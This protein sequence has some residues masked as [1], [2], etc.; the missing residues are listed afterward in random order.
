MVSGWYKRFIV[1]GWYRNLVRDGCGWYRR[2]IV[3]FKVY[4]HFC[5]RRFVVDTNVLWHVLWLMQMFLDTCFLHTTNR[6]SWMLVRQWGEQIFGQA[7]SSCLLL[8]SYPS[9]VT[10]GL[11]VAIQS[12]PHHHQTSHP[13]IPV[14]QPL[15]RNSR[16]TESPTGLYNSRSQCATQN[17]LL[18][19]APTF[20]HFSVRGAFKF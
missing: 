10:T 17:R 13:P 7:I 8:G 14:P 4:T 9:F 1:T 2:F 12:G 5:D 19:E 3:W 6:I 18:S 11:G 20:A 16:R 15:S